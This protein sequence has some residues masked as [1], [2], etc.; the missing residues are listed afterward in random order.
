MYILSE[1]VQCSEMKVNIISV[2][3]DC[4][5]QR[6]VFIRIERILLNCI[7]LLYE[8]K[9]HRALIEIGSSIWALFIFSLYSAC[10]TNKQLMALNDLK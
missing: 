2:F 9:K 10:K 6:I 1:I 4:T 3:L 5:L 7:V 8:K